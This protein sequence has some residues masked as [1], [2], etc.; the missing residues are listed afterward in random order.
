MGGEHKPNF[1]KTLFFTASYSIMDETRAKRE[2]GKHV[3][4]VGVER[5]SRR[6]LLNAKLQP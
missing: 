2:Q 1:F 3:S 5:Y 4:D 6:F